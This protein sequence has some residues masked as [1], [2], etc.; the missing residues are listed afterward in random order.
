MGLRSGEYLGRKRN[1]APRWRRAWAA[2][3]LFVD[4]E[5]VED[6]HIAPVQAGRELGFDV[7][8][9]GGAV[10][11]AVDDPGCDQGIAA[12][13]C[14]EG[15]RLPLAEGH[16][17]AQPLAAQAASTQRR[18]IGLYRGFVEEDEPARLAA[19]EGLAQAAPVSALLLDVAAFLLPGQKDFFYS[20]S[21]GQSETS[22]GWRDQLRDPARP[23]EPQPAQAW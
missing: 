11:G 13:A 2:L 21:P 3:G 20:C 17:G 1:Q 23:G 10:D 5:V 18:H 15:L 8:V 4:I 7:E 22:T 12:Q 14:N 6:D 19:H 9:E 16:L